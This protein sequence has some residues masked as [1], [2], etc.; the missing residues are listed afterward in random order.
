[1]RSPRGRAQAPG[2]LAGRNRADATRDKDAVAQREDGGRAKGRCGAPAG[3]A[4]RGDRRAGERSRRLL[5]GRHVRTRRPRSPFARRACA[6]CAPAGAGPRCASH[7]QRQSPRRRRSPSSCLPR[8]LR[9]IAGPLGGGRVA[10]RVRRVVRRR[11]V[12]AATRRRRTRLQLRPGRPVGHAHGPARRAHRPEVAEQRS[13]SAD[14][15]RDQ[16]LRRGTPCSARRPGHRPRQAAGRHLGLGAG[17]RT[18]PPCRRAGRF[19]APGH[20]GLPSGSH[21]RQR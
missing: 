13:A 17:G 21:P 8:A 20:A 11:C 4:R 16:A 3:D 19:Q 1:M 7:R 18:R 10:R 5:R 9:R 2:T 14:R 6:G 15:G 12:V